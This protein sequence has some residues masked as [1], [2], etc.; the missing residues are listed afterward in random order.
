[1]TGQDEACSTKSGRSLGF[2]PPL[3]LQQ[4]QEESSFSQPCYQ[5]VLREEK[6][7]GELPSPSGW[8]ICTQHVVNG[9]FSSSAWTRLE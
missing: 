9:G 3:L 7:V 2:H 8:W 5:P 4:M 6:K 1:M